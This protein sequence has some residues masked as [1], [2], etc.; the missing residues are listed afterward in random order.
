MSR[1]LCPRA[2][3]QLFLGLFEQPGCQDKARFSPILLDEH[4]VD[5]LSE[6]DRTL[7]DREQCPRLFRKVVVEQHTSQGLWIHLA[8]IRERVLTLANVEPKQ[9]GRV[10]ALVARWR[11]FLRRPRTHDHL[12]WAS[13]NDDTDMRVGRLFLGIDGG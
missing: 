5:S 12:L 1:W 3:L 9:R 8:D 13:P 10:A 6:H 2:L 4:V 7:L 11:H